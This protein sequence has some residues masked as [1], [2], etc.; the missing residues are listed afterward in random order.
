MPDYY[1]SETYTASG[2]TATFAIPFDYLET[3][4]ISVE[5]DGEAYEGDLSF[6]STSQVML[7]EAPEAD[8]EVTVKRTT[9][10]DTLLV[11]FS[12]PTNLD[13]RDITRLQK[14]LLFVAQEAFDRAVLTEFL[15]P[16]NAEEITQEMEDLIADTQASINAIIAGAASIPALV[17]QAEAA[18]ADAIAAAASV[19]AENICLKA[20]NLDDMG[21]YAVTRANLGLGDLAVK[22]EVE[23]GDLDTDLIGISDDIDA[24]TASKIPDCAA[25]KEF[26]VDYVAAGSGGAWTTG[27]MKLTWKA[28]ADSGWILWEEGTIGSAASGA[29][30][31][32]NADTSALY[33]LLWNNCS[34]TNAPVSGGRGANAAADFA[35]DK[36][37]ALPKPEGRA[38]GIMGTGSYSGATARALGALVG[39]ETHTLSI[40]EMPAHTH[41]F[42]DDGV[43]GTGGPD[44][45]AAGPVDQEVGDTTG[46]T[47][48]GAAHNNMQPTVF[49]NAMIKL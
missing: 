2:M 39:S 34:N 23:W 19:T 18:A 42:N 13:Y 24:S 17:A 20:D 41:A 9:P 36:P 3:S 44:S 28:V 14:Q 5:I 31:R 22:D 8:A 1:A 46:S 47:G 26:V 10:A 27:D 15:T 45:V 33:A 4:H 38:I 25:V 12:T 29:S 37:I 48:G 6:P 43:G 21:D 32:A 7:E 16:A 35:A 11:V 49:V 30:L 40:P